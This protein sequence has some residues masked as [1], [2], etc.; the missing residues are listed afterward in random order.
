MLS[1]FALSFLLVGCS[2]VPPSGPQGTSEVPFT[3]LSKGY[4]VASA[5][6]ELQ[7]AGL[8]EVAMD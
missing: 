1:N 8:E 5:L 3:A 4:I 6:S 2:S 7:L